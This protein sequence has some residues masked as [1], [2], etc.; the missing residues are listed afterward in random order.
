[1]HLAGQRCASS[2]TSASRG[3]VSSSFI[4]AAAL[5]L[6]ATSQLVSAHDVEGNDESLSASVDNPTDILP[7]SSQCAATANLCL[8]YFEGAASGVLSSAGWERELARGGSSGSATCSRDE[9]H[10]AR[11]QI[12]E[13]CKHVIWGDVELEAA[14]DESSDDGEEQLGGGLS[15]SLAE[16]VR[17]VTFLPLSP[18]FQSC[19]SS[20]CSGGRTS[21]PSR[22]RGSEVNHS[23]FAEAGTALHFQPLP[24]EGSALHGTGNCR[25]CRWHWT[26]VGCANGE[27][28]SYCHL[29]DGNDFARQ[30][31]AR[32]SERAARLGLTRAAR[33]SGRRRARR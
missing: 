8:E 16:K 12:G 18:R 31:A 5:T 28:C 27:R 17:G 11:V 19:L 3:D 4:N 1:M 2:S 22:S 9:E 14:S 32:R 30:T 24:S 23:D 25:A 7:L 20:T 26:E 6:H 29:C 13:C 10:D 15:A 33:P 21:S